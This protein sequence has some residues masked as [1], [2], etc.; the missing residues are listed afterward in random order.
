MFTEWET[1]KSMVLRDHASQL[2]GTRVRMPSCVGV[3]A[4]GGRAYDRR[5][6]LSRIRVVSEF[7]SSIK[8]VR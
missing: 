4:S 2:F 6:L 7:N 8:M 5:D 3:G 1:E